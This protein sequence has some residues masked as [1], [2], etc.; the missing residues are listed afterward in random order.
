MTA[1]TIAIGLEGGEDFVADE[2][3]PPSEALVMLLDSAADGDGAFG[4]RQND[5]RAAL[6]A[7]GTVVLLIGPGISTGLATQFGCWIR[8]KVGI[9]ILPWSQSHEL[10]QDSEGY[11]AVRFFAGGL[12]EGP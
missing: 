2:Q 12:P 3:S 1:P 8:T 7:D 11:A 6:S 5:L 4:R 10:E 9:D